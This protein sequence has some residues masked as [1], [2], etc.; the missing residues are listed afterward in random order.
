MEVQYLSGI[1]LY[2]NFILVFYF[3]ICK[4]VLYLNNWGNCQFPVTYEMSHNL[5][6]NTKYSAEVKTRITNMNRIEELKKP[7]ESCTQATYETARHIHL[8]TE[9]FEL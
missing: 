2:Y 5:K 4:S 7:L 9:I 3:Q 6:W 1:A 8:I